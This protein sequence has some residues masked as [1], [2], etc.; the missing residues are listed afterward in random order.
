MIHTLF[1]Y[2]NLDSNFSWRDIGIAFIQIISLVWNLLVA[3]VSC[4]LHS[5]SQNSV[6]SI[7]I[8]FF[9]AQG[10]TIFLLIYYHINNLYSATYFSQKLNHG[11]LLIAYWWVFIRSPFHQEY[12]HNPCPQQLPTKGNEKQMLKKNITVSST[13]VILCIGDS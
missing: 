1:W 2:A 11:I 6:F 10:H 12:Q 13:S 5:W 3:V 8:L 4:P 7:C 9:L